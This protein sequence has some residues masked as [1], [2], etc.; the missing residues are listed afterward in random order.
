MYS[1]H[2]ECTSYC[3]YALYCAWSRVLF[4]DSWWKLQCPYSLFFLWHYH[5]EKKNITCIL[6]LILILIFI[7]N[8]PI[9]STKRQSHSYEFTLGALM[10]GSVMSTCPSIADVSTGWG[11]SCSGIPTAYWMRVDFPTDMHHTKNI[12][13]GIWTNLL[14]FLRCIGYL[15]FQFHYYI[16]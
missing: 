5:A 8:N 16:L 4:A 13:M 7:C 9:N 15:N 6:I 12:D 3:H 2:K 1:S 10:T 11:P 14:L